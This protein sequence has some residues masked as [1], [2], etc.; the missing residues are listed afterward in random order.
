MHDKQNSNFEKGWTNQNWISWF[1]MFLNIV[2]VWNDS[3]DTKERV[4][5]L[6]IGW[7]DPKPR[8][9]IAWKTRFFDFRLGF[10]WAIFLFL[11]ML[12]ALYIYSGWI[13][14]WIEEQILINQCKNYLILYKIKS[15]LFWSIFINSLPNQTKFRN[16]PAFL[17]CLDLKDERKINFAINFDFIPYF[18]I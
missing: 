6:R 2:K 16:L 10:F 12:Y 5:M 9:Q 15:Y 17:G 3:K 1:L 14:G 13:L 7:I 11:F 8:L 18:W 4:W